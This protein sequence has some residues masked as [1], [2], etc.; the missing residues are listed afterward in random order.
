MFILNCS[1]LKKES[2][3]SYLKE[4]FI[5]IEGVG[6]VALGVT[7]GNYYNKNKEKDS[8]IAGLEGKYVPKSEPEEIHEK[9]KTISGLNLSL[10]AIEKILDIFFKDKKINTTGKS[11]EEKIIVL[12]DLFQKNNGLENKYYN[13]ASA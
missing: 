5:F 7:A 10:K 2:N 13:P 4:G 12:I 3:K 6:L 8:K 9:D 1:H 11:I